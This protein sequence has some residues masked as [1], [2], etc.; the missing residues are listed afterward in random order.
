MIDYDV[1]AEEYTQHRKVHPEVLR[2]LVSASRIGA[3][4]K[5]LEM[6]CGNG[7]YIIALRALAGSACWGVDSSREMLSRARR[8]STNVIFQLGSAEHLDLPRGFF[9]LVFS[10]DVIHHLDTLLGHFQEAYRVLRAGGRICTVTDS[11]WIIRHREPLAVYFPE[12]IEVDLARYPR[13]VELKGA[14]AQAG[15]GQIA[16]NIVEFR[17]LLTDLQAYRDKAFSCLHLIAEKAFEK[18]IERLERSLGT[19]PIPCV[20][21]YMLLWGTK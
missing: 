8:R 15:F 6:G 2:G 5:V 21:R 19:G 7:N 9:D 17:Y 12:T 16:E 4:S 20:S 18:G 3:G 13:I 1:L 10:V 14:M 11:E